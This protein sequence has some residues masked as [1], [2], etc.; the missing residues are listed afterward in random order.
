MKKTLS[1]LAFFV[2]VAAMV[3][4]QSCKDDDDPVILPPTLTAPAS[5]AFVQIGG[6]ADVTFA[7]T[8]P[9][10]FAA[11]TVAATGGSATVKTAP[12]VGATEGSV[13]VEYTADN[14]AG[15]GTVVLTLSDSEGQS[16]SQTAAINKTISAPP[17]LTLSLTTAEAAQGSSVEVSVVVTAAN[18]VK[19]LTVTGATS[20]PASPITLTG[21][22]PLTQTVSIVVPAT[23]V[24]GSTI[25]AVFTTTDEQDL[26]S[27]P[28]ALEIT[29]LDA[30]IIL[31]GDLTTQTLDAAQRYLIRGQTFV[32]DGVTITIPAG[33]VLFGEKA[34]K[35]TL[36]VERGGKILANGTVEAPVVMTSNQAVNARDRG[37]WGGL[38]ILGKA[39]TNQP[40]PAIEGIS[41]AVNFG[42]ADRANDTDNSGVYKYLR[43]EYAGIELTPNNETNGITMGGVGNGTVMEYMQVSFGG[44]DSFEWFGGSVN[45]RYLI[46]LSTWD[47][48]FDCDFG[49]SGN[50]QFGLAV[51]NPFAADQSQSNAF[52][53]DNGPNDNDTGAGTYTT[54][55]FSNITVYG[56]IDRTGRSISANNVHSMD[57]RR[58]NATSIFNS[59]IGGFPTGL[60]MNQNSVYA[61]YTSGTPNG[62]LAN[63]ILIAPVATSFAIGSGVSFT[64][65]DLQTYWNAANSTL[66]IPAAADEA[67]FYTNL[68]LRIDN[69]FAR[70]TTSTYPSD[71]DFTLTSGTPTL[72]T[73]A[74]F[75]NAKFDEPGRSGFFNETVTYR[76][77]FGT[78][79]WTNGWSEFRPIEKVY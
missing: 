11:A 48:D 27:S 70:S 38:V 29:V 4:M 44:D 75:A 28:V 41:P 68:G 25:T 60:R 15:A 61:Q 77:A 9:G 34:T 8:A 10:G 32:P 58:R 33:T 78:T 3:V 64:A 7:F 55:T 24:V 23:A 42:A 1:L 30:T 47:D 45:G 56:P 22:S 18:G 21:A 73:G 52:E 20:T 40:N 39:F 31:S 26:V 36:V 46:A 79:D 19:T 65:T 54:G 53:N 50:I 35:G 51:R 67:T 62:V 76:G 69:F 49:W 74:S 16:T 17:S 14:T 12:T 43:V 63:N 13:V 72:S 57:L 71:P 59:V 5:V 37:D 66:T 6:E 2:A